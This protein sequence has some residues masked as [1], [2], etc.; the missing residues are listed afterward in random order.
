MSQIIE[1]ETTRIITLELDKIKLANAAFFKI[2][3]V[4]AGLFWSRGRGTLNR[5]S[6]LLGLILVPGVEKS[7]KT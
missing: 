7:E 4:N 2:K 1:L 3:R 5:R 6:I